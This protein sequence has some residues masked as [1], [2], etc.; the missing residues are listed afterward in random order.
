MPHSGDVQSGTIRAM[1]ATHRDR[2]RQ[3]APVT[4]RRE[5]PV[6]GVDRSGHHR[7]ATI[8]RRTSTRMN[9]TVKA[10]SIDTEP[11]RTGGST[12]RTGANTGSVTA[13]AIRRA[14]IDHLPPRK[15]AR[16]PSPAPSAPRAPVQPH[17]HQPQQHP[18]STHDGSFPA[19]TVDLP[20]RSQLDAACVF[21]VNDN[22]DDH[23]R[24]ARTAR[25]VAAILALARWDH[26]NPHIALASRARC[27]TACRIACLMTSARPSPAY[28]R[29]RAL[30][31]AGGPAAKTIPADR[32]LTTT[33]GTDRRVVL[34]AASQRAVGHT[35]RL[36]RIPENHL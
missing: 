8:V 11:S 31:R 13:C 29:H 19:P 7:A 24:K 14:G 20:A 3:P 27:C 9:T 34:A 15:P 1:S 30:L 35:S 28:A 36:S 6:G 18:H 16:P 26:I 25:W 4:V 33:D 32:L 10:R 2:W 22:H 23:R 17:Q 21:A 5:H 12:R